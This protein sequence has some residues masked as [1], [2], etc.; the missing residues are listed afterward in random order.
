ME[1]KPPVVSGAEALRTPALVID[2]DAVDHNISVTLR[3][4]NGDADR[5]RPHLKTAKLA[6]TMRRLRAGGV[7][8]AKCATT[9]ELETACAEGFTDVL[10]AYPAQGPHPATVRNIADRYPGTVISALVEHPDMLAAWRG[11]SVGLFIDLNPGMARTGMPLDP[12]EDVLALARAIGEAG[13]RFA[14]LHYY[15]GHAHAFAAEER[16]RLVT[17]G[18]DRL[19][20]LVESLRRAGCPVPEVITAGTPAFPGALHYPRFS[21]AGI[22]HRLSPGTVVYNDKNSLS[23]LPPDAGY[24][25]AVFVLSRVISHPGPSRFC[26]DAG[27]K[28]VSAD[29]GDPTCLVMGHPD[30]VPLHPSEEHL[31]VDVPPGASLPPRGSLLWL[32]PAHVCPT[33]NNFDHAVIVA[34]GAIQGVERV[35]AR[36]RHPPLEPAPSP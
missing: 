15:D 17:E 4:L 3:M 1:L 18:Y 10:L 19:F 35:T 22:V 28:S 33:V 7:V 21:G 16:E 34:G 25:P 6:L 31:P 5:W 11:S 23:Q 14:G 8:R 20:A 12:A 26:C 36:G 29:A 32:L 2:L 24:R 9:L 30:Y 13:L 27:H